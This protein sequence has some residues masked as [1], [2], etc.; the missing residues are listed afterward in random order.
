METLSSVAFLPLQVIFK[1][2]VNIHNTCT[3]FKYFV[4]SDYVLI[5]DALLLMDGQYL[6]PVTILHVPLSLQSTHT[7]SCISKVVV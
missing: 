5:I 4:P 6:I 7:A 3:W 2:T 1:C